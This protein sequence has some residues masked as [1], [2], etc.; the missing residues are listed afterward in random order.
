MS[1][2]INISLSSSGASTLT[3]AANGWVVLPLPDE[4]KQMISLVV[5]GYN[6]APQMFNQ[7]A[8][9]QV[10]SMLGNNAYGLQV[11]NVNI[12]RLEWD[13]AASKLT[14]TATVTANSSMF[15]EWLQKESPISIT[16]NGSGSIPITT[17]GGAGLNELTLDAL[18]RIV[19]KTVTAE[20]QLNISGTD[21]TGMFDLDF[22]LPTTGN[23]GMVTKTDNILTVNFG[24]LQ[25]QLPIPTTVPEALG[26]D[27]TFTLRVPP[28]AQVD[29]LPTG[30]TQAGNDYTW[31][32]SSAVDAILALVTGSSGTQISYWVGP[33]SVTVENIS[34]HVG[35]NILFEN[36][37]TSCE[38]VSN[39]VLAY[40][41]ARDQPINRIR[42]YLAAGTQGTTVQA[43]QLI[44]KPAE[45]AD[46]PS[47]RGR[48]CYYLNIETTTPTQVENA[49]VEFKVSKLWMRVENIDNSTVRLLRYHNGAWEELNTTMLSDDE[50]DVYFSADTP[51]FS[52]FAVTGV[53]ITTAPTMPIS[54]LWMAAIVVIVL[55][56]IVVV[57]V[58]KYT[59]GGSKR[60][61]KGF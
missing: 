41:F 27:A 16:T 54:P 13:S 10:Q 21:M 6:A 53:T 18:L 3:I 61:A 7:Q 55:G 45:V 34:A 47:E 58:W 25:G 51:G 8:L 1:W 32:G 40:K 36:S 29:N 14:F 22:E 15:G 20:L 11:T 28:N 42:V 44:E 50:N 52:T 56:V 38:V 17:T 35:E 43:Q 46:T 19:A 9:Q 59:S 5:T 37:D 48:V 60:I 2:D 26:L 33:V 49:T 23:L 24:A 12:S 57:V 31:T 4:Q 30:Y 39:R